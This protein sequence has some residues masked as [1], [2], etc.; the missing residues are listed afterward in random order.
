M[1]YLII[2][3]FIMDIQHY[4]EVD[5]NFVAFI[6]EVFS[7]QVKLDVYVFMELYILILHF[8]GRLI[9]TQQFNHLED[10]LLSYKSMSLELK[11]EAKYLLF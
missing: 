5:I 1:V 4:Q 11:L 6:M 7:T 8:L 9:T 3:N 2:S 10:M